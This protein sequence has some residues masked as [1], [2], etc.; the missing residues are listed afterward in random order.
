MEPAI[1]IGELRHRRF[2]PVKHFFTYPLFLTFLDIDK[3]AESMKVSPLTSY[4]RFNWLSFFD[5]D[6]FGDPQLPMRKRLELDA[7]KHG[8]ELPNGKIFLL[9]H[10]R[11]LGY[12]FNPVSFFYC[13][14]L[15]G[16]LET[17]LAEVNNT[18]GES[19]NYWLDKACSLP[20]ANALKYHA[21][22]A[23]HVSPFL[24]MDLGYEFTF[25]DPSTNLT[26]HMAVSNANSLQFDATMTMQSQPWSAA[27]LHR[28]LLRYPL[29]TAK[30]MFQIHWQAAKL[31]WKR[32]PVF[33]H[34]A[35][36]RA[37]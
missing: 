23:F 19:H 30:V 5:R 35:R 1:Y 21:S 4:N 14:D 10:L 32:V 33:T 20:S 34:P 17:I 25:T 27:C 18:F 29:Q 24:P 26:A 31:L 28:A 12:V 8:I 6:H 36:R 11:Y 15:A 13:Y 9:T 37:E 7:A 22:K 2:L 3:I 16:K